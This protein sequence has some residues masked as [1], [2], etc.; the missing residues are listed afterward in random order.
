MPFSER[1]PPP[2][3]KPPSSQVVDASLSLKSRI[4]GNGKAP[5][6][7]STSETKLLGVAPGDPI[8]QSQII[9]IHSESESLTTTLVATVDITS[10]TVTHCQVLT[11]SSWAEEELGSWL[12]GVRQD[13]SLASIGKAF[14]SYLITCMERLQCWSD[15]ARDVSHLFVN[16]SNFEGLPLHASDADP[17][18]ITVLLRQPECVLT[19]GSVI[20]R[21]TWRIS[22]NEEGHVDSDVSAHPQ[23]PD[24]W[25]RADIGAELAKVGEVFDLLMQ[26]KSVPQAISVIAGLMFPS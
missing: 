8:L 1:P 23:F 24:K 5:F 9:N 15:T 7:V 12:R 3:L 4:L 10:Q 20:L 13:I 11:L 17:G 19:R 26:E 22:I 16:I 14:G 25:Q 2:D 6:I 21:I 18:Q